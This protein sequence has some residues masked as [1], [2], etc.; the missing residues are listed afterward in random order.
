MKFVLLTMFDWKE[1]EPAVLGRG[2]SEVCES[3]WVH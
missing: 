3:E 2:T 1:L